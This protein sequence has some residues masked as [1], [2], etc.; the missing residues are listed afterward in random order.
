MNVVTAKVEA[1]QI[2][3][4]RTGRRLK[5]VPEVLGA[6]PSTGPV[7]DPLCGAPEDR[8]EFSTMC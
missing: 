7:A 8:G 3:T 1:K 6:V 5:N 4:I 2:A